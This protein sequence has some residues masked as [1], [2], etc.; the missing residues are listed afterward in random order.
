MVKRQDAMKETEVE[1]T[2]R[3]VFDQLIEGCQI[4]GPDGCY[5][6][7]N[8][9]AE[10]QYR[11]SKE[12]LVGKKFIEVWPDIAGSKLLRF[13][14]LCIE[15]KLSHNLEEVFSLLD[16]TV[17]QFKFNIQPIPLGVVILSQEIAPHRVITDE[18]IQHLEQFEHEVARW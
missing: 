5:I 6:Y 3:I 15:K 12:K 1:E 13:M 7:V 8:K 4:V 10:I 18:S 17:K 2:F 14:N 16:G 11:C 9:T